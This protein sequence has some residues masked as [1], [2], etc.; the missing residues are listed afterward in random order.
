MNS[1][2]CPLKVGD[3]VKFTPSDYDLAKLSA[4]ELYGIMPNDAGKIVRIDNDRYVYLAKSTPGMGL[5]WE[6]FTLVERGEQ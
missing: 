4:L 6:M 3:T 1:N 2:T 5:D